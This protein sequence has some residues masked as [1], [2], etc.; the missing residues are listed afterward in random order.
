MRIS[1]RRSLYR[2]LSTLAFNSNNVLRAANRCS[3]DGID[4]DDSN[5]VR[6]VVYLKSSVEIDGGTG[7]YT[8]PY[9]LK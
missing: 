6:P 8:D 1:N 4:P 3:L 2:L 7:Q 5:G 9:I